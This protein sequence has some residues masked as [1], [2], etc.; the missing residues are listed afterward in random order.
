MENIDIRNTP[1]KVDISPDIG[2]YIFC[3]T[4]TQNCRVVKLNDWKYAGPEF[5][6]DFVSDS[7][8]GET[9]KFVFVF[10]FFVFPLFCS[11]SSFFLSS[12]TIP[13]PSFP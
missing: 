4:S 10:C 1:L 5:H 2:E 9:R 6:I 7:L 12:A 3:P 8:T 11:I 13:S